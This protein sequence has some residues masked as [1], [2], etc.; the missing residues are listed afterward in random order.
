MSEAPV[1][2]EIMWDTSANHIND[3]ANKDE[4]SEGKYRKNSENKR[5]QTSIM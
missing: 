4:D 2:H 1:N 3:K 5:M